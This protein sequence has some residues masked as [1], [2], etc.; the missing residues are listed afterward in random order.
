M[1]ISRQFINNPVRVWLTILLLG[2]GG[3]FALL[4]IGR[5]EDPAFTIKTAVVVTHYP[6]AS[7]Q[8]VEEEVTLPLEN[9]LQ[10]LPYLDNVSSIS[11]NGLSQITVNIASRYHSNEL[12]QIWDELRRRVGD[13]SRQFPPGV[14]TPFVN[15]DFGDVFGFFFAISGDEFSNP[16]LVRY[17]EQLRRELILVPGVAKVAIGGAISQQVN[18]DI[19]LTKMAARGITLNQL[20]ALLSRLNVVS[21]AGEITSG[22][23]SIRL[24][25]TGEFENLDELADLIITPSGT[26]AATR[27][28]DIATLSRGLNESPASIYHA[29][30]KKAVTMGVSFIPGVNVI[31]VGHAL[32]AK[33]NQMSAEKPAGIQIDLFYD[34]AAEVGHSVNGFIINFLMALAI[35]DDLGAIVI[36][37][38]FYTSDLSILS[39]SVA[40]G[41]IAVLALLN[42]FNVRRIGI[43]ILVGMVLWT[44]VLKS[45]VHATLAG[46]IVGFFV[47]LKPQDGKSPAKQLEHV[48]HPWVAFMI[49]PLFAFANAGVSL[50]GVTLDGL[51]SV[52]PLGIIAGLF[53]GKPLG[54]SLFCWLATKLKLASL[55]HGTTFKQIMAVGVL[56]GIG[57]TMSIFISTLAFGAHAPELIVWAKLGILIGSLL[58]AV[59]GYTLLKVKLSGQAVQA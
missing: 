59:I 15:D 22:S 9:A 49:L 18:I 52:L 30:G 41:A 17:A 36:I 54:I 39:L 38:L 10:Q 47:P 26:G 24:H 3:I 40:A 50:G 23:E 45:G 48:L 21:S 46:V 7:A 27:L 11:S 35:I 32:E 34:Q 2:I 42:I 5:L 56:C 33:L 51:T 1:D 31:D 25:P 4:N 55:P 8:Q 44:A 53:I 58:A 37:A 19:S 12:P 28:R 20:S 6:G 13:A 14:V 16:E 57:F 43:Y 29:N